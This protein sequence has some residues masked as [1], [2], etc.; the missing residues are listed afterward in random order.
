MAKGPLDT[1][2]DLSTLNTII[3]FANQFSRDCG[4]R[5]EDIITICRKMETEESL[6][7]GDGEEIRKSF[8]EIA[9]GAAHIGKSAKQI[10]KILDS[11]LGKG[12]DLKKGHYSAQAMEETSK[13]ADSAGVIKKQ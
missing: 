7:G 8:E 1:K 4:D 5:S 10:S 3:V 13:A 11:K 6:A 2:I 9:K 12:L